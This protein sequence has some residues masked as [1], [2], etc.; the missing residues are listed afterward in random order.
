MWLEIDTLIR[1]L[2][3][4]SRSLDS[5][6]RA[7]FGMDDGSFVTRPYDFSEVVDTLGAIVD[8]DWTGF[9]T[10]RLQGKAEGAPLAGIG[11]GGYE[12]VYRDTQSDFGIA[13][14]TALNTIDLMFSLGL[15][16]SSNGAIHEVIWESVA[17]DAGLVAG[18]TIVAVN[19][20]SFTG[21]EIKRAI[22]EARNGGAI[23]LLVQNGKRHRTVSICYPGGMR[24]PHL[25]PIA[26]TRRRL[27]DILN[28][29]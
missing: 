6:A 1:Q 29:R 22:S 24:Y 20:R 4:E 21:D 11:R 25:L 9:L 10:Q 17:F 8:Y 3:D 28:P 5:F 12:L 18:S 2:S 15:L 14:N 16:L 13:S 26:G 27:D 23:D 7:F 19:G